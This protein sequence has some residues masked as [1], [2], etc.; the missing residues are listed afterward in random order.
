MKKQRSQ[1]RF[2]ES[3]P[4]AFN[5]VRKSCSI[6]EIHDRNQHQD[7]ESPRIEAAKRVK[8]F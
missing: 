7:S 1:N 6:Q 2:V 3:E 5:I 4:K 8:Y